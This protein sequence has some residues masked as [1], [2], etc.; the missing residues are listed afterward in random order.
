MLLALAGCGG[1]SLPAATQRPT[2]SIPPVLSPSSTP[3]PTPTVDLAGASRVALTLF[4][5]TP[6]NVNDP[7]AGYTWTSVSLTAHGGPLSTQ[8]KAR[9]TELNKSGYFDDRHCG[10]S[11][12][13]GT[14]YGLLTEPKV[15]SAHAIGNGSVTV[16]LERS[17][18]HSSPPNL[19][20]VLTKQ[21]GTWL[22][23]DLASGTGPSASIFSVKP[24]C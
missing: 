21:D 8:L 5:R 3:T 16:V 24:N 4:K 15:L 18:S 6:N 9:M 14:Q 20:V 10:E 13:V 23:T 2:S 22:V 1:P 11:Y 7:S 12:V 17:D 19:T